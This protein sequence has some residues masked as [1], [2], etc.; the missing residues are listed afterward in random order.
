[1]NKKSRILVLLILILVLIP[2]F[3]VFAAPSWWPL[4]PCGTSVNPEPCTRCDLFKLVKNVIDFILIGIVPPVAAV[5]FIT[6]GLMIVLAG[7]SPSMYARGIAIFKTTFWGLVIILA[8]WM[9]TNTFIK[10]FGPDQIKGSWFRY[11][12]KETVITGP[13]GPGNICFRPDLLVQQY[14]TSSTIKNAPELNTLISCV[15]SRLGSYI[16]QSKLYTY[17]RENRLCNYTRGRPVC[18]A[19]E[20]EVDSCHYGGAS[21]ASGSQAVDFNARSISEQDLYQRLQSISGVC[22]F[23]SILFENDHTHVSTKSCAGK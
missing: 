23:G 14:N 8:S 19:C 21:G 17:E 22:N 15:N 1:M 4:V 3:E 13:G 12:C 2:I 5:L 11:T 18:G 6:A 20:H 9:I 16:D 10:S 7:A